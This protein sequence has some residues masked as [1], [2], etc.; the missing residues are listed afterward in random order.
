MAMY[1]I[2]ETANGWIVRPSR[3]RDYERAYPEQ[4]CEMYVFND[5][6][7]LNKHLKKTLKTAEPKK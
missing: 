5:V 7:E 2:I 3:V 1:E 4:C 6:A